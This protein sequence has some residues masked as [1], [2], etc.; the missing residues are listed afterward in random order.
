MLA[1][2]VFVVLG[3]NFKMMQPRSEELHEA[4]AMASLMKARYGE[5]AIT[6]ARRE[7][8]SCPLE[9]SKPIWT[10]VIDAL[11]RKA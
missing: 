11:M 9:D 6:A 8:D 1:I 5:N 2:I 7:A 4:W 10:S 3:W